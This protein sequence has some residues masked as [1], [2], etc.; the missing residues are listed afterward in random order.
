MKLDK[1][2][3]IYEKWEQLSNKKVKLL[4]K[5]GSEKIGN[6]ESFTHGTNSFIEYWI[7][8]KTNK[9]FNLLIEDGEWIKSSDLLEIY[10]YEDHS[11]IIL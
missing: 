4:L 3:I 5:D 7:L 10:F 2:K 9:P 6:I 8:N 1:T 11:I